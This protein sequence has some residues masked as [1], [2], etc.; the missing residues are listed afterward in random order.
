MSPTGKFLRY[1]L[2]EVLLRLSKLQFL[3][4]ME[5]WRGSSFSRGKLQLADHFD[6]LMRDVILKNVNKFEHFD[7]TFRRN[8]LYCSAE[9][10]LA[11]TTNKLP[12]HQIFRS[13][14]PAQSS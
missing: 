10:S 14:A 8:Q 9:L 3:C 11:L 13:Y 4:N 6:C 7:P 5:P 12:L 2:V 1:Q